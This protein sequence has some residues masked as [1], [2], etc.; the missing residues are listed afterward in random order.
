MRGSIGRGNDLLVYDLGILPYSEALALQHSLVEKRRAGSVGDMLLLL[1]H[2]PV[3]T[4][5]RSASEADILADADELQRNNV[6]RVRIERG[7]ETTYHGP[8]QLVGYPIIDLREHLRSLKKYVYLLEEVFITYLRDRYGIE[9]DRD[10]D[11]RGVWVADGKITAV[12]IAVQ[13]RV[14]FH[15]F[16]FN[17]STD[18]TH[19][20]WIVPCGITD[21]TQTSLER[22]C[23]E[24]PDMKTVKHEIAAIFADLFGYEHTVFGTRTSPL[25]D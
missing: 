8:G 10:N 6:E 22:E 15:G 11:H 5:G 4:L 2:P 16:A 18:L 25:V 12:G 21:R 17:V 9:A 20:D 19:F 3:I 24:S 7:G 13:Q 23:G 1:E 14:T